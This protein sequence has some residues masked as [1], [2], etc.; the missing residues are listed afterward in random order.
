LYKNK[1]RKYS[2]P[3]SKKKMIKKIKN[4]TGRAEKPEVNGVDIL[5]T[6][7]KHVNKI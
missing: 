5:G 7:P 2:I 6:T 3:K 1:E 4:E